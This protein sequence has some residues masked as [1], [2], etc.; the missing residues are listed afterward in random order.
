FAKIRS[1]LNILSTEHVEY[2]H[3]TGS[4]MTTVIPGTNFVQFMYYLESLILQLFEKHNEYG[5]DILIY[6]NNNLT[7]NQPLKEQFHVLLQTAYK[8]QHDA[9]YK[10]QPLLLGDHIH[11]SEEVETLDQLKVWARDDGAKET[12]EKAF[13]LVELK[14]LIQAFQTDTVELKGRKKS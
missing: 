5:P 14:A 4:K 11:L 2:I 12:F 7:N 1:C 9:K 3:K 10:N 6:I 13:T 8:L